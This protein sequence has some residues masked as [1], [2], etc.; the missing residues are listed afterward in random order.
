MPS[1]PAP[2]SGIGRR[3]GPAPG[4]ARECV[5][6]RDAFIDEGV[7]LGDRVKVQNGALVYH[8]VDRRGRR[9]HRPGR[10]PHERPLPAGDHLGRRPGPGQRLAGQPDHAP[11]RLLH[12]CRGGRRRRRRCRLV[13]DRRRR[14]RRH[15]A[16]ADHALVVGNPARRLGWVCACGLRLA[17]ATATRWPPAGPLRRRRGVSAPRA[18]APTPMSGRGGA[19]GADPARVKG[20]P[21]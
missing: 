1:D 9:L 4:S 21:A 18:S 13:R 11:P 12:R 6:G 17:T 10:D 7:Q 14:R 16:R 5:I 2:A 19:R 15:P 3:C 8:G 20:A